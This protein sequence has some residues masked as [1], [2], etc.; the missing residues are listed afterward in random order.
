MLIIDLG[1]GWLKFPSVVD[2]YPNNRV[3]DGFDFPDA[4]ILGV[5]VCNYNNDVVAS[6]LQTPF[7]DGV[8]D[9]VVMRQII[10]HVYS[11]GLVREAWRILKPNGKI[12]LET[13]NALYIFKI[14]RALRR[15]IANPHPEHIQTFTA[16]ELKNLLLRNGF[17]C[18]Q[19]SYYNVD[20]TSRN[21][22]WSCIKKIIAF[23]V[24]KTFPMLDRDIRVTA[25]K[26]C[27]AKF[28]QYR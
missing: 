1:C 26:E 4:E 13:P 12:L 15:Q 21:T 11:E 16:A 9:V 23:L 6:A 22:F 8:A 25:R 7:R 28:A 2:W 20:V 18:L 17:R 19:F 24:D 5:D 3:P 14:L 27:T 10:E